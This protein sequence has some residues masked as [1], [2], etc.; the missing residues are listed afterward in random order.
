MNLRKI[1]AASTAFATILI[2]A[3]CGKST[4][5]NNTGN[6]KYAK[7]QTLNW[8]ENT[9]WLLRIFLKQPIH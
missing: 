2:L 4:Q 1:I 5:S 8:T 6:G 7:T 3:G 9:A